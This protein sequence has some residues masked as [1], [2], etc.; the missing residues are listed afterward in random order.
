MRA[1]PHPLTPGDER[2]LNFNPSREAH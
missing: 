2:R 1:D